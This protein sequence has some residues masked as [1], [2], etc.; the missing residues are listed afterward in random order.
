MN[1]LIERR[2]AGE[3]WRVG[4]WGGGGIIVADLTTTN[5]VAHFFENV[6]HFPL[7]PL[8]GVDVDLA[9]VGRHCKL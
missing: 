7:V 1:T 3:F 4:G 2:K 6:L 5:W 9:V 8:L